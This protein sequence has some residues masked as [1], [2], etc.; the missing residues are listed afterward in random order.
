VVSFD[1]NSAAALASIAAPVLVVLGGL[2][3]WIGVRLPLTADAQ[4]WTAPHT[5]LGDVVV[6]SAVLKSR[7]RNPKKIFDVA[8]ARDPGWPRRIRARLHSPALTLFYVPDR[9]PA[10]YV[11]PVPEGGLAI[12]GKGE[13]QYKDLLPGTALPYGDKTRLWVQSGR[14][15]FYFKLREG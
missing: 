8:L 1:L 15:T 4:W 2:T 14:R 10:G 12:E 9:P 13:V 11:P 7:T 5:D 6:V 3:Y